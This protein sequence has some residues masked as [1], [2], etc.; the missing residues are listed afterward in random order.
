MSTPN[1][2][3][4]GRC[5]LVTGASSGLG[6]HFAGTLAEAGAT[7][8]VAARRA[9]RLQELVGELRERGRQAL[10]LTMDVSDG[11][12]VRAGFDAL[13]GQGLCADLIVNNAGVAVSRPLLEQSEADYDSVVQTNLKG[14]WLVAQE[15]ARRMVDAKRD[16]SIVNMA[17][18]TGERVAGGVAPYCASKAALLQLTRAMALELAPHGIR[19]NAIAPGYVATELNRDFLASTAGQRLMARIPQR[20]FGEPADLDGALLLL[21]SDAGRFMTGSVLAVDG[22]HLVSSL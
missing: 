15:G 10:A 19:V 4:D 6:R 7:V 1:F 21:A 8:I 18:I 11:A 13:A 14:A 17:S 12:S 16:G 20:R 2:R 5:A 9:E 3:L 22:G